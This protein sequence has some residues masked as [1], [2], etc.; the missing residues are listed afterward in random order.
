MRLAV[1]LLFSST[2]TIIGS[3]A[4]IEPI[5]RC[6]CD[7]VQQKIEAVSLKQAFPGPQ[8]WQVLFTILTGPEIWCRMVAGSRRKRHAATEGDST[9]FA[10]NFRKSP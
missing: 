4:V 9:S 1:V 5:E 6:Q 7:A 3:R 8:G 2:C 10:A